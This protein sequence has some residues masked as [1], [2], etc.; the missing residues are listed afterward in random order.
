ME[1]TLTQTEDRTLAK[2]R[3][4]QAMSQTK[5]SMHQLQKSVTR[6]V[7]RNSKVM[8]GIAI[9]GLTLLAA[10]R[11]GTLPRSRVR[12]RLPRLAASWTQAKMPVK[13]ALGGRRIHGTVNPA[14]SVIA[15][16]SAGALIGTGVTMLLARRLFPGS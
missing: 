11:L 15:L 6:F 3:I 9:G 12:R 4:Q 8:G 1:T 16:L 2:A 7:G 5:T 10:G 13:S 14:V